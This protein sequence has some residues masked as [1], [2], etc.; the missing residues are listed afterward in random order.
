MRK[1]ILFFLIFLFINGYSQNIDEF[2]I[3]DGN[4]FCKL[5]FDT[6]KNLDGTYEIGNVAISKSGD[7]SFLKVG[8]WKRFDKSG[9]LKAFGEYKIGSYTRCCFEGPCNCHYNYKFGKWIY[10]YSKGQ[11]KAIGAY[12]IN[13]KQIETNCT[14]EDK[15]KVHEINDDWKYWDEKGKPINL[16]R[17]LKEELEINDF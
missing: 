3:I 8:I 12:S 11:L 4:C 1:Y 16:S 6:L 5:S 13:S 17:E 7:T 2:E 15:K 9:D 10:Y 14:G